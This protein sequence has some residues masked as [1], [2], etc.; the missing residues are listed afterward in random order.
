MTDLSA[1]FEALANYRPAKKVRFFIAASLFDGDDAAI[2][3]MR[4][5][6]QGMG[7]EVI[8]LGHNRSVN[9]VVTAAPVEA[10]DRLPHCAYER[11]A[12]GARAPERRAERE[13]ESVRGAGGPRA[14]PLAPADHE[15]A[16]RVRD[17][18]GAACG[19]AGSPFDGY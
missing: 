16:V 11:I 15:R 1:K 10:P 13:R 6:P 12:S 2:N 5:I 7:A 18:T 4:R 3:I 8:H 14:H 17:S 9:E 19:D